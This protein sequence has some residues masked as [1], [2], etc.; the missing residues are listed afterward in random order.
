[1]MTYIDFLSGASYCLSFFSPSF[2]PL[3]SRHR[4]RRIPGKCSKSVYHPRFCVTA[5]MRFPVCILSDPKYPRNLSPFFSALDRPG[6]RRVFFVYLINA[7]INNSKCRNIGKR[8]AMAIILRCGRK[9]FYRQLKR[10]SSR[11]MS[12]RLGK[13]F[14]T[15]RIRDKHFLLLPALSTLTWVR[16]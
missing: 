6:K 15:S 13:K 3:Y 9:T 16:T 2:I 1:M 4:T 12:R 8:W 10:A 7:P 14:T 5:R 11:N